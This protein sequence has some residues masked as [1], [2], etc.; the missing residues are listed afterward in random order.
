MVTTTTV[1]LYIES[2]ILSV[3]QQSSAFQESQ[4]WE[5]Q[6]AVCAVS[7]QYLHAVMYFR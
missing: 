7:M 3:I 5:Q 6:L 2:H 4:Q 1:L